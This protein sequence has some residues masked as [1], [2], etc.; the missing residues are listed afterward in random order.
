MGW[1]KFSTTMTTHFPRNM[2]D[3][4]SMNGIPFDGVDR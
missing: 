1:L 2:P 4:I 3:W